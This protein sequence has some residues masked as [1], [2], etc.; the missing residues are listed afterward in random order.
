ME[1]TINKFFNEQHQYERKQ[2]W[3][4]YTE[5]SKKGV[6]KE[7]LDGEEEADLDL[8]DFNGVGLLNRT[9]N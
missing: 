8:R 6:G 3:P 2:N 1:T 9:R 4:S 5:Q 7:E